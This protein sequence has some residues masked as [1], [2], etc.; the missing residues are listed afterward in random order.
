MNFLEMALTIAHNSIDQLIKIEN[1]DDSSSS[2]VE[3]IAVLKRY[4]ESLQTV[5]K[6]LIRL[7]MNKPN[8]GNVT[9]T[10]KKLYSLTLKNVSR[11][12]GNYVAFA[13]H[14]RNVLEHIK[15]SMT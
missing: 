10:Y 15:V 13:Q 4:E 7:C 5:L 12:D 11:D 14:L 9:E 2:S 8:N 3:I 1:L 6:K